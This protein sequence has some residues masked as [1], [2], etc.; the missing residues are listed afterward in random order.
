MK[1]ELLMIFGKNRV[2]G[3]KSTFYIL[4]CGFLWITTST[5]SVPFVIMVFDLE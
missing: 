2:F 3:I 5:P 1:K 4:L